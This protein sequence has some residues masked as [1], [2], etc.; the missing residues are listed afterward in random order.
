MNL[1]LVFGGG[2]AYIQI[3]RGSSYTALGRY[4]QCVRAGRHEMTVLYVGRLAGFTAVRARRASF[5]SRARARSRMRR[6]RQ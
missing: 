2:F 6:C 1:R 4:P 5:G 3:N